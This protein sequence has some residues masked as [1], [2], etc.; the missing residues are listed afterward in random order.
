MPTV[1]RKIRK[2]PAT[3]AESFAV[4]EALGAY[5]AASDAHYQE[6]RAVNRSLDQAMADHAAKPTDES[7]AAVDA[8][9]RKL[10]RLDGSITKAK[11]KAVDAYERA[12]M[13]SWQA[14][15]ATRRRWQASIKAAAA[16]REHDKVVAA[17]R[18]VGTAA[19]N[20]AR[21][22]GGT[23]EQAQAAGQAAFDAA[24]KEQRI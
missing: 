7:A 22:D 9:E 23:E 18:A 1:K 24:R 11:A 4:Y 13:T 10:K 16:A 14:A 12:G 20:Q 6:A 5:E 15:L 8:I 2:R 17:A 19:A 3:A 21:A